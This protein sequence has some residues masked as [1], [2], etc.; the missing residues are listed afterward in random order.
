MGNE[1]EWMYKDVREMSKED[2]VA[3][4]DPMYGNVQHV[5]PQV[6]AAVHHDIFGERGC[7]WSGGVAGDGVKCAHNFWVYNIMVGRSIGA[8]RN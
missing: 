6:L 3:I 7:M 1:R 5:V 4:L 2:Q 8:Q